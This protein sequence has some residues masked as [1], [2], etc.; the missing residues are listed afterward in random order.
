MTLPDDQ[1]RYLSSIVS[2]FSHTGFD[3]K[4]AVYQAT[5]VSWAWFLTRTTDCRIFQDQRV[6]DIIKKEI[7]REHGDSDFEEYLTTELYRPQGGVQGS[8]GAKATSE[9]RRPPG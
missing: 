6:P 7:F 4:I 1:A 8:E 3:G 5:L 9:V 2:C